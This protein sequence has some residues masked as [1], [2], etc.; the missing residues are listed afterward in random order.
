VV[1]PGRARGPYMGLALYYPALAALGLVEVARDLFRLP[2]SERFGVRAVTVSLFF[3]TLPG[4]RTVES[5]KHLRRAAFGAVVGTGRAPAVKTLRRKLAELVDQNRASELGARL[6]RRWVETAVVATAYLYVDGH[7]KAYS[8][9]RKLAE[10]WNS[11][12]RMPLPGIHTYHVADSGGRPL[13]FLAEE[14]SANLAKAMPRI[15][16]AIREALGDRPFSVIFDRG[17]YDGALLSW[18]DDHGIGFI[19]YQRGNPGL[20]EESFCRHETR[21]EGRRVRFIAATDTVTVGR[22]GPWR[23]IVVRTSDGHQTPILTNLGAKVGS[24]RIA[25]LMFARW[26]QENL[27]KYLGTHHGLDSLIS[28][29]HEAVSEDTMVT[30]P[31]RKRLD[32]K[33]A[34]RRK[35]LATMKASLGGWCL[36]RRSRFAIHAWI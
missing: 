21:F 5:A 34:E 30:N 29:A 2:R 7:V 17:G 19:T 23:R 26:R 27:F 12:R 16:S 4:K 11:Q 22:S 1:L 18:L 20:P 8:G 28:Y 3:L 35:E 24:A 10:I 15:I 36:S 9:K 31:E 6:A 33:I 13:L 25:C 32:Q 14:L